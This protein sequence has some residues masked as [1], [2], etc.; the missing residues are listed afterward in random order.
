MV[1]GATRASDVHPQNT[2]P[3]DG[4]AAASSAAGFQLPDAP[5]QMNEQG[6]AQFEVKL[7]PPH[8]YG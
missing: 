5:S 7:L 2:M 3:A 4:S 6:M 1:A 8:T